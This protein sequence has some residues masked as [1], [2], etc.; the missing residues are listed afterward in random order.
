[1][2]TPKQLTVQLLLF[3]QASVAMLGSLYFSNF[4]DPVKNIAAGALF[5]ADGGLEPCHLCWWARILMYPL[6][7]IS[8]V[9]ILKKDNRFTDYV[10]PLAIPG[11]ILEVYHYLTQKVFTQS[12]F[13]CGTVN[14]CSSTQAVDYFGFITIPFLCLTAFGVIIVLSL[15][16]TWM[17]TKKNPQ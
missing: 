3:A 13:E 17:E 16:N 15:I 9:G 7:F 1:M 11:F 14:P 4:G 12:F 6:V 8:A 5:H 10:V 2:R